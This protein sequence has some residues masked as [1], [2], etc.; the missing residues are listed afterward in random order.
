MLVRVCV[1]VSVGTHARVCQPVL[2]GA[3]GRTEATATRCGEQTNRSETPGKPGRSRRGSVPTT[4]RARATRAA[5]GCLSGDGAAAPE[6][7]SSSRAGT[8]THTFVLDRATLH[9]GADVCTLCSRPAWEN[10]TESRELRP[11]RGTLRAAGGASGS[12]LLGAD[13]SPWIPVPFA[14]KLSLFLR[15]LQPTAIYSSCSSL[16]SGWEA[17]ISESFK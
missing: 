11:A 16:V 10:G 14:Q 9:R 12:G 2:R 6:A 8:Y 3:Q 5:R 1:C 13:C 4:T 15:S 17:L 7:S